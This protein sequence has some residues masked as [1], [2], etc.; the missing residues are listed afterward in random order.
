MNEMRK[1][2]YIYI[3]LQK[4][5]VVGRKIKGKGNMEEDSVVGF[6]RLGLSH[7]AHALL[8]VM[9]FEGDLGRL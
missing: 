9:K 3:F 4:K 5:W 7:F 8:I 2:I 6:N 1:L